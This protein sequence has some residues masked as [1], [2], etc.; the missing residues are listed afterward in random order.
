MQKRAAVTAIT[1]PPAHTPII[2]LSGKA[3]A[4]PVVKKTMNNE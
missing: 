3:S 2:A 4:S 1:A